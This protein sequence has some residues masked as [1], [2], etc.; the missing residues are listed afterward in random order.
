MEI[1][2]YTGTTLAMAAVVL[3]WVA[4]LRSYRATAL[5]ARRGQYPFL[6]ARTPVA[7]ATNYIGIQV[8][9]SMVSFMLLWLIATIIVFAFQVRMVR[10]FIAQR[11]LSLIL[12]LL[13]AALLLTLLQS[14]VINKVL[15]RGHRIIFRRWFSWADLWFSFTNIVIGAVVSILRLVWSFLVQM[16]FFS[17]ADIT[18]LALA[19]SHRDPAKAA[20]NSMLMLDVQYNHP[21]K[22][23]AAFVMIEDMLR[24][25]RAA[26][27]AAAEALAQAKSAGSGSG[28]GGGTAGAGAMIV[29]PL[30]ARGQGAGADASSYVGV[31]AAA[32][33][34]ALAAGMAGPR[35]D[36]YHPS[37]SREQRASRLHARNRWFLA[38][39]LTNNPGLRAMR[40]LDTKLARRKQVSLPAALVRSALGRKPAAP[41][42]EEDVPQP[43]PRQAPEEVLRD[44]AEREAEEAR[45]RDAAPQVRKIS[46]VAHPPEHVRLTD[47]IAPTLRPDA[48]APVRQAQPWHRTQGW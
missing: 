41:E 19:H 8:S 14:L 2:S 18:A 25:R 5:A 9:L 33:A 26:A 38:I 17:R 12:S 37:V 36:P 3:C 11:A 4:M 34:A 44:A 27:A 1:A 6:W 32:V 13:G 46:A 22:V 24:R 23:A 39:T 7:K 21:L 29:N 10:E 48:D 45:R 20:F 28:G 47:L 30:Y 40:V 35:V 43:P 31:D 15:T 16:A 42:R